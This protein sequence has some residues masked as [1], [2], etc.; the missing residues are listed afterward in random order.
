M[1]LSEYIAKLQKIEKDHGGD[2]EVEKEW[3][4]NR[5]RI[6]APSPEIA[7]QQLGGSLFWSDLTNNDSR[8]GEK[9][10]RV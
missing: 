10:V 9:V 8:K 4:Y 7:F 6:P 5:D 2:L 1:K 3:W